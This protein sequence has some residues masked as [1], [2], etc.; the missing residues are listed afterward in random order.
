MIVRT[1]PYS[2]EE[3]KIVVQTRL[4]VEGLA[5]QEDALEKLADDGVRTSL[6]YALSLPLLCL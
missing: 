5:I 6:R 2:R 4:K 1:M 3:I